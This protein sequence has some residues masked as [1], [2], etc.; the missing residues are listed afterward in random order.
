M[1]RELLF[2]YGTESAARLRT[3][4]RARANARRG[5]LVGREC[6]RARAL[7]GQPAL[8]VHAA[9]AGALAGHRPAAASLMFLMRYRVHQYIRTYSAGNRKM[10]S[11]FIKLKS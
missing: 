6:R 4:R 9:L 7:P 11:I 10:K 8:R 2:D 5:Q 3:C 1:V